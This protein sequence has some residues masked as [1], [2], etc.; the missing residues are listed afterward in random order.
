MCNRA[1]DYFVDYNWCVT[2][3]LYRL[4]LHRQL[5]APR[6]SNVASSTDFFK[7]VYTG[8]E[9]QI[10]IIPSDDPE[11]NFRSQ[12][13]NLLIRHASTTASFSCR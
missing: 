8:G 10:P 4:G 3:A 7:P 12:R 11:Q 2:A 13:V 5:G 9:C 1:Y 6:P